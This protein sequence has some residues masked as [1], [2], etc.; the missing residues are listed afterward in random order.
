MRTKGEKLPARILMSSSV[1]GC[2]VFFSLGYKSIFFIPGKAE[3]DNLQSWG[4]GYVLFLTANAT[5]ILQAYLIFQFFYSSPNY[6][7]RVV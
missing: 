3:G 5:H 1:W 2:N 7:I 6:L 4:E